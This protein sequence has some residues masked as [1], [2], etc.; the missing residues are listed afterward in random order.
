MLV[1]TKIIDPGKCGYNSNRIGFD[2]KSHFSLPVT[3]SINSVLIG[4]NNRLLVHADNTEKI[5][6]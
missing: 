6:W 1:I 2:A 3:D 4:V 5:S